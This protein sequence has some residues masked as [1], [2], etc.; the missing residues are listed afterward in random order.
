MTNNEWFSVSERKPAQGDCLVINTK[1]LGASWRKAT[2]R[3]DMYLI[4]IRDGTGWGLIPF[5][6]THWRPALNIPSCS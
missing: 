6:A 5:D 2:Y 1:L 4:L 3:D